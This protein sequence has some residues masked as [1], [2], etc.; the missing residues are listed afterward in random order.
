[1]AVDG[2][3]AARL[4]FTNQR[5][6]VAFDPR[7]ATTERLVEALARA[8]Y[9]AKPFVGDLGK[10]PIFGK[11]REAALKAGVAPQAFEGMMGAIYDAAADAGLLV[12]PFDALGEAQSFLGKKGLTEQQAAAEMKPHYDRLALFV[13][14]IGNQLGLEEGSRVA[15][16]ELM[17][18]AG[19]LR[20]LDALSKSTLGASV[21]PGGDGQDGPASL[22][23]FN[24]LLNDPR[25]GLS[26]RPADPAFREK[27]DR[28]AA[29]LAGRRK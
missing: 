27:L 3:A 9:K 13:D 29:Q 10:D 4:N 26:G 17:A 25:A 11:A 16:G 21:K 18:T 23:E 7:V 22:E 12:K 8:G 28:M 5:A 24:K 14:G 6:H 1:M 20:L 15:L 19:G 2:V